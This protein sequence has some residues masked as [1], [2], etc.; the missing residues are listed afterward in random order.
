[1]KCGATEPPG[2]ANGLPCANVWAIEKRCTHDLVYTKDGADVHTGVDVA[3]AVERVEDDA[4]FALVRV[5]DDD[6]IV[7][8]LRDEHGA[9]A[10]CPEGVDH[11]VVREYVEFLLFLAL[12]VCLSRHS[13][14]MC[15]NG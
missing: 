11:D 2:Q 14:A 3:A 9:L 5:L 10:G 13:D 4:V 15:T 1:M 7:D 6:G 8:L 12:H